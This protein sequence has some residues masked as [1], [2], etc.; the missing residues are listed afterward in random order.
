MKTIGIDARFMLRPLRGI[1]LYVARLCQFLPEVGKN[2]MFIYFINKGFE[3]NDCPDNYQSRLE[4]IQ[5]R[6]DNVC[7]INCDH[8]AE[9]FWEQCYLPRL[10]TKHR[11][12][13]LH[14]PGNRICFFPGVPTVVTIHDVIEYLL[15]FKRYAA[16]LSKFKANMRM[17]FYHSRMAAY[18]WSTYKIALRRAARVITV[19]HYSASD[20]VKHLNISPALV[21]AIHHGLDDDYLL[22]AGSDTSVGGSIINPLDSR[23]YVLMLGGDSYQK[24]PE[25]AIAAWSK[26]PDYI[27]AKYRLKIAGFCGDDSSALIQALRRHRLEGSVDVHGWVTQAELIGFLR[28]A[29]LFLYLSRYEGFGFPPLHA[30]A[31][32]TPVISSNCSSI[33]EVLGDVGLTFNP[34]DHEEIA[35]GI[36]KILTDE[37]AWN[38]QAESGTKRAQRFDWNKSAEAHIGVYEEVFGNA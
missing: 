13:L 23:R 19:S 36:T 16:N 27:R 21:T 25:G 5:K 32:G 28:S 9:I 14:T 17:H 6:H 7:I 26:V 4:D 20:I 35:R 3:H 38:E 37:V 22:T 2:H 29:A 31:C 8:D 33:P 10:I 15:L 30:M 18:V 11:I 12:D 34:D 24:N 1:P